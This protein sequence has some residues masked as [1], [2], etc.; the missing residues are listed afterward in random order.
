MRKDAAC[1]GSPDSGDPNEVRE[2]RRRAAAMSDRNIIL[3]ADGAVATLTLNR[4]EQLNPLDWS[5]VKALRD[6]YAR[7][8]EDPGVR[9]VIVTG[10]GRAFSAGGDLE[11]YLKLYRRPDEF[12]MFLDD[13][14]ALFDRMEASPKVNIA[15]VNGFCVAGGLE[16]MLAC[17]LVVASEASR[18]GDGH[19]N[20]GQLPGAGG[21]QRLPRA[22]GALRAK[23]L[24]LTGE[25]IDARE[26]E[27]IG[28]VNMVVP[29]AELMAAANRLAAGLLSKSPLG[30][31]GA[32]RLVNEGLKMG[33]QES[34]KFEIE[35]VHRYATTSHDATEGLN[36]FREKRKPVFRGD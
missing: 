17:D 23:Q 25:M 5:T 3:E 6:C 19:L 35:T 27:R 4:P 21:S 22:I 2:R 18:I 34:L 10:A 1:L 26:A 36:A 15:A 29:A 7:L 20:F 31:K 30:L 9:V 11:G 13:L 8:D 12:R 16:L 28:L 24:M 32:K 33:F 14:F